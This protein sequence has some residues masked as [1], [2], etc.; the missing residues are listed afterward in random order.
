M[1]CL[2]KMSGV[3]RLSPFWVNP[4][5]KKHFLDQFS[6]KSKHLKE[7]SNNFL[8]RKDGPCSELGSAADTEMWLGSVPWLSTRVLCSTRGPGIFSERRQIR[9]RLAGSHGRGILLIHARISGG[10]WQERRKQNKQ[11]NPYTPCKFD[12]EILPQGCQRAGIMIS[13][14]PRSVLGHWVFNAEKNIS[15]Y[16]II[17]F[18]F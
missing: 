16:L 15:N 5:F 8:G 4:N 13:L 14:S 10:N 2:L 17:N 11:P 6:R 12:L 3:D 7:S 9:H 1:M 18:F